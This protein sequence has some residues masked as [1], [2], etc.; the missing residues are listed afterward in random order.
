MVAPGVSHDTTDYEVAPRLGPDGRLTAASVQ[1]IVQ[2]L[3]EHGFVVI[4]RLLSQAETSSGLELV[5]RAIADPNREAGTFAS[6]TDIRFKRRDFTPLPSND[7]VLSFASLLC[8]RLDKALLEYCG[9]TRP[10]L[11]ISTLTSHAG[12]SHQYIHRDPPGVLC[13][14]AAVDD[15][16]SEQGGTVFIPG[17]HFFNGGEARHGGKANVL[18]PLIQDRTNA[19]ILRYNLAKLRRMHRAGELAAGEYKE[20][21]FSRRRDNHQPNLLRFLSAR[22]AVFDISAYRPRSLLARWRNREVVDKAFRLVQTAPQAG[23]VILYRS[24]MLHAGPDNRTDRPRYFFSMSIARDVMGEKL[25]N[26][27]YSPHSTLRA[28]PKTLGDLLDMP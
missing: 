19:R 9:R 4:P 7:R 2:C 18:M 28:D 8:K 16:S 1:S 20:R 10:V 3:D 17:T 6:Q 27:G 25:R 26:D 14:F 21:V 13:M 5:K 12:A 24:D 22:N 15:V 11:E 23:T